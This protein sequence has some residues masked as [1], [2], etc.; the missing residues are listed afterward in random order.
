[1]A[2]TIDELQIDIQSKSTEA[3][4]GIDKLAQTLGKLRAAAKGGV[5]LTAV[6]NQLTNVQTAL[7]NIKA[8]NGK[9]QELV[10]SL[11]PLAE[12][13]KSNLGTTLNQLKK[14]PEVI[15]ELEKTDLHKFYNQIQSVTRIIKPL[16]T[17][18]EK[19]SRGFS[20]LPANIQKAINANAKL[21]TSNKKTTSSYSSL[22]K[23]L[24]AVALYYSLKRVLTVAAKFFNETS[25]YVEALNLFT[26]AMGD[27]AKGAYEYAQRVQALMG[28]DIKE[29]MSNIGKF[30][31]M[32][33]GFGL[34]SG[35][36]S[37]MSKQLTQIGYDISSLFNVDVETAMSRLQSGIAGQVKGMR[38]YGVNLTMAALKETALAHGI[39]MS[40]SKMSQAQKAQLR[41]ITIMEKTINMQG[42]LARTIVTPANAMRIL[43]NQWT[44]MKRSIGQIV[45]VIVA[46]FIPTVQAL[47]EVIG[48]AAQSLASMFGYK[49]PS[50]NYE[51]MKDLAAG[52]DE[53]EDGLDGAAEAAKKLKQYTM[54]F[55]ELNILNPDDEAAAS[56][57]S[58]YGKGLFDIDTSKYDYDFL[59]GIKA[60]TDELKKKLR[61]VL[62]IIGL[63]AVAFG[64]WKI[65][66]TVLGALSGFSDTTKLNNFKKAVGITLVVTGFALEFDGFREIGNGTADLMSYIKAGIGAALGVAGSLLIFGTGPVGWTVGI[67]LAIAI[68]IAGITVGNQE[69]IDKMVETAFYSY[70]DGGITITLLSE[71]F[72]LLM[73]DIKKINQPIIDAGKEIDK[74]KE[75]VNDAATSID[76]IRKGIELGAWTAEQKIPILVQKFTD[77]QTG[78]KTVLDETYNN[79]IRAVSGSLGQALADAGVDVP[80]IIAE[81][82][83]VKG[84]A[85]ETLKK[86][87]LSMADTKKSFDDG[88]ISAKEYSD[89]MFELSQQLEKLSGAANPA[90]DAFIGVSDAMK[91]INWE[92]EDAKNNAFELI[93]KSAN[94][95]KTSVDK[96]CTTTKSN[97]E[98][99]R[100]LSKD[101]AYQLALDTMILGAEADRKNKLS[102]IETELG[103][104]F[105]TVQR[106]LIQN[107]DKVSKAAEEEW[108]KKNWIEKIFAGGSEAEYVQDAVLDYQNNYV[109]PI[110]DEIKNSFDSLSIKASPWAQDAMKS[111]LKSMFDT[112]AYDSDMGNSP[113]TFFKDDVGTAIKNALASVGKDHIEEAKTAGKNVVEGIKN[114]VTENQDLAMQAIKD[115]GAGMNTDFKEKLGIHSPSTVMWDNGKYTVQGLADGITENVEIVDKSMKTL[116]NALL[117]RMEAFTNDCRYALNQLLSDFAHSMANIK[118]SS[119]GFV[120]YDKVK[121]VKIPKYAT[122]GYPEQGQL[123][124]ARE[125]GAEMVGSVG[126]R[127]AVANNDQIVE[128]VSAGVYR[129]VVAAQG[130]EKSGDSSTYVYLDGKQ[131]EASVR[132]TQQERGATIMTGGLYNYG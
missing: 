106:D 131:I 89:K 121:P 27:A 7:N 84:E 95:A 102:T 119:S 90:K 107:T 42:D 109:K 20:A 67:A 46:K 101:P 8:S 50:I 3:A 111:L 81:I 124:I 79:I 28:I 88:K 103:N 87:A 128:A 5:G 130:Q 110:S 99:L 41:Y 116:L 23:S 72:G 63:I 32:L 80:L 114:G 6:A 65:S 31:Q 96:A 94:D 76:G 18:M 61:E 77:L 93:K 38:E 49:L 29:W 123:F 1:M 54:G 83:K 21:T 73:D 75:K 86:I 47:V 113:Q 11:K 74:A 39:D 55:D 37:E 30:N 35:N 92:N 16:A 17:E 122:G 43:N 58:K 62:K 22:L 98:G 71:S 78:T 129:A 66:S 56:S 69:Q 85:D 26:V 125:A 60:D 105:D 132:K 52:A 24:N 14:V 97:I 108:A 82:A 120:S 9:V 104:V 36:A 19:V 53:T 117:G 10:D 64:T 13:G 25:D 118:V 68:A 100:G 59:S 91:G 2:L 57:A 4:S 126:G 15:S 44:I 127:T 48:E 33:L 51:G 112:E 12:I 45:T 70:S 40:T 34:D 115:M